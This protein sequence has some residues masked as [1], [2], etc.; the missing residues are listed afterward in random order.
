MEHMR[1]IT[2]SVGAGSRLNSLMNNNMYIFIEYRMCDQLTILAKNLQFL[3][4]FQ[5]LA[6]WDP[7]VLCV[8]VRLLKCI[9]EVGCRALCI[10]LY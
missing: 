10:S 4:G 5:H 6:M 9:S 2:S 1:K 7:S 8:S 3:D